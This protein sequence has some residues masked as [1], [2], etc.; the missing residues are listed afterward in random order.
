MQIK[1]LAVGLLLAFAAAPAVA[2]DVKIQAPR[3]APERTDAVDKTR[4]PYE[5]TRPTDR[6]YYPEGPRVAHDPAFIEPFSTEYEGAN[7]SGRVGIAGWTSPNAP[8][9][10]EVT[11][12]REVTGWFGLGFSVT[13]GGPPRATTPRRPAP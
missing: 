3:P 6:D 9:G 10:P 4:L 7:S 12:H 11:G 2:Q 5:R 8:L 1:A 13:W